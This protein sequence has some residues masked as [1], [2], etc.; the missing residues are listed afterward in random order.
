MGASRYQQTD[1]GFG[2]IE[3]MNMPMH[4]AR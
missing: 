4:Q 1:K 3:G 2:N